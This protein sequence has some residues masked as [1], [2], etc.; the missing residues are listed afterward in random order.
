[1]INVADRSNFAVMQ[2]V[3]YARQYE[4]RHE[5]H[6]AQ[7][8]NVPGMGFSWVQGI[9]PVFF[10]ADTDYNRDYYWTDK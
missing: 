10:P 6:A 7:A 5:T 1:M 3:E 9:I 4:C 2:G 8:W